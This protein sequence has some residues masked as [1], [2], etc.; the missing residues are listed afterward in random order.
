MK[1]STTSPEHVKSLCKPRTF[2]HKGQN[3]VLLIIAGSK[4][5]HGA[6][7]FAGL[8]ASRIVD[9]VY[10]CTEKENIPFVKKASPE[11]IVSENREWKKWAQKCDAVLVGPGLGRNAANKRILSGLL[12]KC[13]SKKTILDAAAFHLIAPKQLHSNCVLTPHA[14]EFFAFFRQK[15]TKL[16]LKKFSKKFHA[17]IVLKGHTDIIASSGKLY[18]NHTGNEGMTKGGTGDILA[19]LIA[20][21]A[22]KNTLLLSCLAS[23]YLNG[24][25]GDLLKK[26]KGTMYDAIDLLEKIPE[27]KMMCEKA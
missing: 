20:G 7:I 19:G 22:C 15:P 3:G 26:E 18:Y 9:I 2:S 13:K 8:A 1:E 24:L 23:C 4:Q 5:F 21:F 25:A 17:T 12:S 14:G 11:F 6:S 27:A 16:A 10:F